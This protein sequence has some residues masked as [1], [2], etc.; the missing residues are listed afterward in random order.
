[1]F[2][3]RESLH[4]TFLFAV[5]QGHRLCFRETLYTCPLS[6]TTGLLQAEQCSELVSSGTAQYCCIVR[7]QVRVV[8]V[9]VPD[10]PTGPVT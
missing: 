2:K 10:P 4:F 5:P 1:M 9:I 3:V 8:V 7:P 6:S